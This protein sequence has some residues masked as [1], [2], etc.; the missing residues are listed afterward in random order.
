[1]N[2]RQTGHAISQRSGDTAARPRNLMRKC[3]CGKHAGG[4]Q[5]SGCARKQAQHDASAEHDARKATSVESTIATAGQ[6]LAGVTR[7][8][9]EQHFGHD[10][11][12]VRVH[13]DAAAAG[14]A[15]AVN[16]HAY[17]VGSHVV[18]GAGQYAPQTTQGQELLAH[19]LAHVVQ[20]HGAT[21]TLGESPQLEREADQAALRVLS[22]QPAGVVGQGS[23]GLMRQPKGNGSP[24]PPKPV[25]TRAPTAAEQKIIEAARS[26]AAVRTQIAYFRTA[27]IGPGTPDNRQD[28]ADY[29]RRQHARQLATRMF[30]WDPPNM[31]QVG[32]IVNKMIGQVAS[33]TNYRVAGT[34]DSECG[35][36]AG[37]VVGHQ[38]PIVLCPGFFANSAEQRVRTLIHEAA[39]VA[40]IGKADTSE[41]YCV[42]FDCEHGCGGFDS[43]DS[44]AQYVNCMSDQTA[45]KPDVIN[46]KGAAPAGGKP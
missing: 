44:W 9:M 3:A 31:Q 1:M 6:P 30:N 40:G 33:G 38:L 19:E 10:F 27:G 17:T 18:F 24:V 36:R 26:A 39:H 34:G 14:S 32:D 4:G 28:I 21:G 23:V 12:G 7:Q 29:E 16:A 37:Y 25:A 8:N 20:Q 43:A 11:S 22:G 2:F 5:C 46:A 45:D 13:T 41:S 35:T 15:D 42:V